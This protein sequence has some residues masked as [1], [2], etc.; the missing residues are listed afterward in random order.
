MKNFVSLFDGMSCGQLSVSKYLSKDEYKWFSSEIEYSSMNVTNHN[1][2]KTK[3]LGDVS[4]ITG[5]MLPKN[6][7]M[8]MGGSPCQGFSLAGYKKGMITKENIEVTSLNQYLKLKEEGFEF[9][10]QSYLFWEYI[11]I[12][13]MVKPKYFLLENVLMAGQNKKWEKIISKELGVEA[14]RINSN[15]VSAQNR[16][17]LY[18]TNITGVTIPENTYTHLSEVVPGA[19]GGYGTR[20]RWCKTE[21]KY[22]MYSTTRKDGKSNCLTKSVCGRFAELNDGSVLPLTVEQCEVLQGVP[23]GYTDVIGV[24]KTARYQ[25]LGNGWTVPVIE[26]IFSFIPEF[27]LEYN[28]KGIIF[29]NTI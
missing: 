27:H 25:M 13:K 21:N 28:E 2:P 11:R 14:I 7:Y 18:W 10:G 6:V 4:K 29:D 15:L 5:T 12:V 17:R 16:D 26:H 20:G 1:F 23:V 8:V 24:T 3:Q 9:E 19:I 22:V